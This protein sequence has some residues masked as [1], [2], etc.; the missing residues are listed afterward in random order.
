MRQLPVF[1]AFQSSHSKETISKYY[2]MAP[3][4]QNICMHVLLPHSLELHPKT[5]L[6]KLLDTGIKK[7][8]QLI[9]QKNQLRI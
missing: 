2:H 8:K 5:A 7:R 6:I 3:Q 4:N 1:P 9:K